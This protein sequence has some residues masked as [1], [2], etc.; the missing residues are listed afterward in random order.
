MVHVIYRKK[1]C[2][3]DETDDS[4]E[5]FTI[6]QNIGSITKM[7]QCDADECECCCGNK[8]NGDRFTP[9]KP[10]F[11]TDNNN[12]GSGLIVD[13]KLDLYLFNKL[14]ITEAYHKSVFAS[15]TIREHAKADIHY[16]IRPDT[17]FPDYHNYSNV[18][19]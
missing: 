10:F 17:L 13:K 5:I 18:Y 6:L 16:Y 7:F 9:T 14:L 2:V 3:E 11:D 15:L 1:D 19:L 8:G 12:I 4:L